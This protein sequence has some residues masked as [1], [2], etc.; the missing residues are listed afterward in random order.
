M[1]ACY[2]LLAAAVALLTT[3]DVA[4]AMSVSKA[5]PQDLSSTDNTAQTSSI[6]KRFLRYRESED[7]GGNNTENEERAML[8]LVY[9]GGANFFKKMA[10]FVPVWNKVDVQVAAIAKAEDNYRR[11]FK[12]IHELGYTPRKVARTSGLAKKAL[13]MNKNQLLHDGD[14]MFWLYYSRWWAKNVAKKVA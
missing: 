6:A 4:S 3:S 10:D 2:V 5:T 13:S 12:Q 8:N 9:E 14:Y 7:D 11:M 1:R